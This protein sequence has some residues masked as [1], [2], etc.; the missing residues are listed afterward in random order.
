MPRFLLLAAAFAHIL[1]GKDSSSRTDSD[2][3]TE[4]DGSGALGG[5]PKDD[6]ADDDLYASDEE[7]DDLGFTEGE[8]DE[9]NHRPTQRRGV[10]LVPTS[11]VSSLSTLTGIGRPTL[12][13][14][15]VKI[16]EIL[17]G[18]PIP[19]DEKEV[20]APHYRHT[21]ILSGSLIPFSILLQIP[22]LTEHWYVR[23]VGN[24]IVD[25]KRNSPLLEVSLVLS[26]VLVVFA[27][28]ALICRFL[29][30]RVKRCTIL[31]IAALTLHGKPF[32]FCQSSDI[33]KSPRY[34]KCCDCDR[35]WCSTSFRRWLHLWRSILDDDMF[36]SRIYDNE[37]HFN[38]G[39]NQDAQF[40]SI[41]FVL[42]TLCSIVMCST[43]SR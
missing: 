25:V 34:T 22:G 7:H 5:A 37:C 43:A 13:R 19:P 16:K 21:P 38:L 3:D 23:T 14:W 33:H 12:P 8:G 35:L 39:L 10:R 32:I 11:T 29:E 27:N 6:V 30:R 26:M 42:P 40:L 17:V 9:D 28:L 20:S 1:P 31:C 15:L 36:H 2:P 4:K 24:D 18:A 41:W